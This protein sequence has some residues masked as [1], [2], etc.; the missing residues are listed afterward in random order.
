MRACEPRGSGQFYRA[1]NEKRLSGDGLLSQGLA[2]QVSSALA[3]FTAV[4][5]MGTGGSTPLESPENLFASALRLTESRVKSCSCCAGARC[6]LSGER[7]GALE[8]P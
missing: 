1:E 7:D 3:P 2:P 4:F 5:G 6:Q 8:A